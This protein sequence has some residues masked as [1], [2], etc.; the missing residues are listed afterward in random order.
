LALERESVDELTIR[1]ASSADAERMA[2]TLAAAFQNDPAFRWI[3]PDAQTRATKLDRFFGFAVAEDLA[4]G[5]ALTS[6]ETEVATL[7]RA[8]GRHKELPLGFLRSNIA[9]VGIFGRTL[10]RGYR[11]AEAMAQHHPDMPHWYLRY[12]AVAPEAQGKGWGGR[13][14]RAGIAMAEADGLPIYLETAKESNVG[15]YQRFGF[16]ITDEWDVPCGGPR[17]WSMT[18]D[19]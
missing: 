12:A 11:V 14:I 17:F 13:A 5:R 3:M 7:W 6:V 1:Q 2:T 15:L 4:A 9:F 16:S 8:P 19:I 10:P 18:R